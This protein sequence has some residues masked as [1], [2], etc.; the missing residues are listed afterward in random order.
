MVIKKEW[1]SSEIDELKF[2]HDSV[3]CEFSCGRTLVETFTNLVHGD[4]DPDD[5][6]TLMVMQ[7]SRRNWVVNGNRRLLLYNELA[8]VRTDFS[9]PVTFV[10]FDWNM[11][12]KRLSTRNGGKDVQIRIRGDTCTEEFHDEIY[13]IVSKSGCLDEDGESPGWDF[14]DADGKFDCCKAYSDQQFY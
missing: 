9:I 7:Q 4:L 8:K 11:L 5:L 13:R 10:D 6:P 2:T 12:R 14:F 3:K 1:S